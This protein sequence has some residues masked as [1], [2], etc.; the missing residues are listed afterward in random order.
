MLP[1]SDFIYFFIILA[2]FMTVWAFRRT[3]KP[4]DK[5][6]EFEY[7]GFS[8]FWGI[9]M[10]ALYGGIETHFIQISKVDLFSNPFAT[11]LFLSV[12]GMIISFI[13]GS[14]WNFLKMRI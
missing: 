7:I 3:T 5:I 1:T 12:I 4:K 9:A 11:G 8:A 14:I 6:S 13:V 10:I 2:G